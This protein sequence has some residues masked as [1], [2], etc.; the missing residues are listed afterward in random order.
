MGA[1][2]FMQLLNLGLVPLILFAA[3]LAEFTFIR[4]W[5]RQGSPLFLAGLVARVQS[6]FL[7]S[8]RA[9][10]H[11]RSERCSANSSES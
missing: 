6:G 10:S 11:L 3:G 1:G 8:R 9:Q 7:R 2:F 5:I 4:S